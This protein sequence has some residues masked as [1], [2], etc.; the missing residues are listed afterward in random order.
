MMMMT[1]FIPNR[2][3][4]SENINLNNLMSS[5]YSKF[6]ATKPIDE[7]DTKLKR[8]VFLDCKDLIMSQM[9]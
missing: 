4:D 2:T 7:I 5:I 8:M 9:L 1:Y 6:Y 3:Q